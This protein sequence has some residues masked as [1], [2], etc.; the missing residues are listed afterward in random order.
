MIMGKTP[1]YTAYRY[2]DAVIPITFS[3]CGV[4][5]KPLCLGH[6][7][8]LEKLENPIISKEEISCNMEEG[9]LWFFNALLVCALSYED[10][11]KYLNDDTLYKELIDEFTVNLLINI[12]KDKDWNIF[13]KIQLFKEYMNFHLDIPIYTEE[14]TDN[15]LPSGTDWKQNIY[16]VFKKMGYKDKEIYNMN[17]RRLFYEWCSYAESEGGIKVMNRYD[18]QMMGK[19]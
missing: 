19:L 17:I 8:V 18:L 14:R 15:S 4:E 5:L 7:L 3:I 10:N 1:D 13:A 11:I 16:L 12:E 6:L 9:M 2:T